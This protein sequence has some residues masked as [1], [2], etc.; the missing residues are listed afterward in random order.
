M[1][2]SKKVSSKQI[3]KKYV[4]RSDRAQAAKEKAA[5]KEESRKKKAEKQLMQKQ[6]YAKHDNK[7][8]VCANC[9]QVF[10]TAETLSCHH[11]GINCASRATRL[12]VRKATSVPSK[13]KVMETQN[14][15]DH[16]DSIANLAFVSL[17]LEKK[18]DGD[19]FGITWEKRDVRILVADVSP[20]A[21]AFLS[22]R[23]RVGFQLV[24]VNDEATTAPDINMD[25]L[26]QVFDTSSKVSLKFRRCDPPL[27]RH[28]SARK[29]YHR[30]S[31]FKWEKCQK[32]FLEMTYTPIIRARVLFNAMQAHFGNELRGDDTPMWA[33]LEQVRTWRKGMRSAEK[34]A[35][36][37][38]AQPNS[39]VM[40]E[41]QSVGSF[42]ENDDDE[43]GELDDENDEDD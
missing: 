34:Q 16:D 21:L 26:T 14:K 17:V 3:R 31:N 33:P 19:C 11:L 24:E 1:K 23:V 42:D 13:M 35:N 37:L 29:I 30:P 25:T 7:R 12:A 39:N 10:K 4:T 38:A 28:G 40:V 32:D 9:E 5:K 15:K 20:S 6:L 43:H 22:A 8:H 18:L 36:R 27:P 41:P 2:L